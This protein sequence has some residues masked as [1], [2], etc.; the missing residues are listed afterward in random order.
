MLKGD[1]ILVKDTELLNYF[2]WHLA[3]ILKLY[4]GKNNIIRVVTIKSKNLVT[5]SVIST[6]ALPFLNKKSVM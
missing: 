3:R 2:K 4:P 1:I 5:T 6:A